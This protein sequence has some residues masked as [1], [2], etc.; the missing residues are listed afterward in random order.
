M[1]SAEPFFRYVSCS[2]T[3]AKVGMRKA[4]IKKGEIRTRS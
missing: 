1:I 2:S 3:G 4:I